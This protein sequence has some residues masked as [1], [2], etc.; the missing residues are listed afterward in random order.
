M[1]G[2]R[3]A[4]L[5]S[6]LSP[7]FNHKHDSN[8]Q[9]PRLP[10]LKDVNTKSWL[11]GVL[12]DEGK[13]LPPIPPQKTSMPSQDD[14]QKL[15]DKLDKVKID[16]AKELPELPDDKRPTINNLLSPYNDQFSDSVK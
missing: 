7:L 2:P 8:Y 9:F 6:P 15:D 3:L 5:V 4:D 16:K 14:E 12:N 1:N 11:K 10:P 13:E